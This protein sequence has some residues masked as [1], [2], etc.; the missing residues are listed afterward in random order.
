MSADCNIIYV[1]KVVLTET[2]YE[3]LGFC[4]NVVEDCSSG[5]LCCMHN[6]LRQCTVLIFKDKKFHSFWTF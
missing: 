2:G 1:I 5:I 3:L 6:V 4:N